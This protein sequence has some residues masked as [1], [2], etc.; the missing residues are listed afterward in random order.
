MYIVY[1]SQLHPDY[2]RNS[3]MYQRV[4]SKKYIKRAKRMTQCRFLKGMNERPF[5][6]NIYNSRR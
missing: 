1:I 6:L 5:V 2:L 3:E 4:S